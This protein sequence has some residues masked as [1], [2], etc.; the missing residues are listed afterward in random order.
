MIKSKFPK[1]VI[2]LGL[3]SLFTDI[4]SEML[5]PVMPV[6]LTSVLGA[7]MALVGLLEGVAEFTAGILKGYFGFLSDKVKKRSI[8][9][10]IGYGL[11]ALSKPLPG[12]IPA[13]P[14][15]IT[16][17]IADRIGKGVR[18][19][20]RD[21]LLGSYSTNGNSGAIF[22][23]H[24]AMDTLG[25][26]LGPVVALVLLYFYP[27]NYKL[28]FFVA[29]IPSLIAVAFTFMVRDRAESLEPSKKKTL[30]YKGFYKAAPR[31]YKILL[32]LFTI[33]S[34]ANSSDV[35]LI[36][37]AGKVANNSMYAVVSYILYNIVYALS[38]YPLGTLSDKIGKK[39]IF[40]AGMFLFSLVYLGFGLSDSFNAIVVLFVFYGVYAA[41]T[42]GVMKAWISDI[43]PNKQKGSAIGLLTMLSSF[44]IMLGSFA[45]GVIWD[46][47]SPFW[48]F[49]V[50]AII[51]AIVGIV[52]MFKVAKDPL[53][54]IN[55]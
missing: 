42:E 9:V 12:I 40:T 14:V 41:A 1:A 35:F 24:R 17:R 7:S 36:L 6:F 11:S 31:E 30:N 54:P 5:Y 43:I 37:R 34:F 52:L 32:V 23:F 51:S 8:F 19:A 3:V 21:A 46:S 26:A 44:A 2:L 33:F 27:N 47:F 55:N 29:F 39:T 49:I 13:I 48:A 28:I 18:T 25:A 20:P 50:S 10:S 16:S 53:I 45:T 22:G 4:A 15:V 38:S